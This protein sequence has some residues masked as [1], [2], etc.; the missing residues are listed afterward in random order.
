MKR[1][2][3]ALGSLL[4]CAQA[5]VEWV[6][7]GVS[8][9]E[10]TTSFNFFLASE[11]TRTG[12][13]LQVWSK[14]LPMDAINQAKLAT[15]VYESNAKRAAEG[16]HPPFSRLQKLDPYQEQV[17]MAWQEKAKNDAIKPLARM[18]WEIDCAKKTA[19]TLQVISP[20]H[21]DKE[22]TEWQAMPDGSSGAN[23]VTL[24]CD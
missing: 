3:I 8:K 7:F 19:R 1:L 2:A 21:T 22:P 6:F 10:E 24:T 15:Q 16:Y 23:L 5:P 9:I 18:L 12:D 4:L 17:T 13:T 14:T 20:T 11:I